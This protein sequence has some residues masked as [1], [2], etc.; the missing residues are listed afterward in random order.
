M[1]A[2]VIIGTATSFGIQSAESGAPMQ[3]ISVSANATSNKVEAKN[4]NG[5]T[6]A[7]AFNAKKVE[8][9]LEGYYTAT[10][11]VT[12]GGSVTPTNTLATALASAGYYVDEVTITKASEDFVKIKYLI[13]QRDGIA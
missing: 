13:V 7:V 5:G 10:N 4:I 6:A 8:H 12:V 2:P 11:S 9:T 3:I 1:P